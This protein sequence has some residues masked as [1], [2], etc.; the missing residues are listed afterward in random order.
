[1]GVAGK[2]RGFTLLET[3]VALTVLGF[4]MVAL[5]QGVRVGLTFW[6]VQG[7]EVETTAELDADARVFR[8]IL[9]T[10]PIEPASLGANLSIEF[11]GKPGQLVLVGR[12]PTG[13]GPVRLVDMTIYLQGGRVLISWAPH[14]HDQPEATPVPTVTEL[15]RGVD[16]LEFSYWGTA[17]R[18]TPAAW[19]SQ[20]E[21]P[22]LPD[23]V[24]IRLKFAAGDKR[25]WPDLI[26]A[27]R[28]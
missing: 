20:W 7:R 4:L 18:G 6:H 28:L 11:N 17:K 19:L 22:A 12:L 13:L 21:G 14:R 9:S 5:V 16:R 3:L 24:R 27:P 15:L 2:T 25:R 26:V 10:V 1:M 8:T 23:L